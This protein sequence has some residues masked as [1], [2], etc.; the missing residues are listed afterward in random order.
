NTSFTTAFDAAG[1]VLVFQASS[2]TALAAGDGSPL[3]SRQLPVGSY[4]VVPTGIFVVSNGNLLFLDTNGNTQATHP[5]VGT[6]Q[7]VAP[8][9]DLFGLDVHNVT[10]EWDTTGTVVRTLPFVVSGIDSAGTLYTL[11]VTTANV[12]GDF[13]TSFSAGRHAFD[14]AV[15]T[16]F[17]EVAPST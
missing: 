6:I 17:D 7:L 4:V 11:Q 14:G 9:G 13:V 15:L 8:N 1:N 2:I 5:F 10:T 3:W 12:G 16:S